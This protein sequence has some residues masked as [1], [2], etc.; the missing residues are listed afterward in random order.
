MRRVPLFLSRGWWF[1]W[2]SRGSLVGMLS[3]TRCWVEYHF[4]EVQPL[5]WLFLARR[6]FVELG[7]GMRDL[8]RSRLAFVVH[9][10]SDSF[11]HWSHR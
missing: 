11:Y 6:D 9:L 10:R 1:G 3:P 4:V 8:G 2:M 7:L 5:C